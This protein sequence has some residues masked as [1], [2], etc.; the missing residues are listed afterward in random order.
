MN[1]KN[2]KFNLRGFVSVLTTFSFLLLAV[3]GLVLFITPPGRVANWTGWQFL[4]L[5]KIQWGSVHIWFSFT[6]LL[7]SLFHVYFNWKVLLNYFKNRVSRSFAFKREWTAALIVCVVLYVGTL[8]E[9][10]PFSSLIAFN[11]SIKNSW[12]QDDQRAPIP[13]AE[14]LT[15]TELASEA[16]I[17]I[18]N[19]M[20][21]LN[22]KGISDATADSIVGDLA[23]A[24]G[25]TPIQL[26]DIAAAG[27]GNKK[28]A[29]KSGM[30]KGSG[31][32]RKTLA[33]ICSEWQLDQQEVINKFKAEGIEATS[34]MIL[35]DIAYKN[36]MKPPELL[37]MLKSI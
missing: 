9:I 7:V 3:S 15:L 13:H 35:R 14:L 28:T 1:N 32:G 33:Q 31:M 23:K 29:G 24:H 5:T 10:P 25:M 20:G 2:A 18:E 27:S 26:F 36:N 19:I 22:A 6:F 8:A 17:S 16:K 30:H 11:D 12:E 34:D 21:N 4:G 37:D